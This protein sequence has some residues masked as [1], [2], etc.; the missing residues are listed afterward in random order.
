MDYRQMK[1]RF[2]KLNKLIEAAEAEKAPEEFVN[3]LKAEHAELRWKIQ[4]AFKSSAPAVYESEYPANW[5]RRI[6]D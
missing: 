6:E 3:K 5:Q 2:T 1:E 4:E